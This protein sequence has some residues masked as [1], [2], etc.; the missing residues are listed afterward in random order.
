M[1]SEGALLNGVIDLLG[2]LWLPVRVGLQCKEIKTRDYCR[3]FDVVLA[4]AVC[5]LGFFA[6]VFVI[7]LGLASSWRRPFLTATMECCSR[8]APDE[9]IGRHGKGDRYSSITARRP[10]PPRRGNLSQH[11]GAQPSRLL[12]KD[13][14]LC[15]TQR[16]Y[17]TAWMSKRSLSQALSLELPSIGTFPKY[18]EQLFKSIHRRTYQRTYVGEL[19]SLKPHL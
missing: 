17:G 16:G 7:N 5:G 8:R 13:E 12:L 14:R 15:L 19:T 4:K 10:P 9:V 2:D 1:K 3:Q 18:D 6:A 11:R